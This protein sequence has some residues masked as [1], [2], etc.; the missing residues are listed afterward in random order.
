M[1]SIYASAN[2][3]STVEQLGAEL[4]ADTNDFFTPAFTTLNI[5]TI[6]GGTAKNII[7]G[8]TEMLLEWRPI[9]GQPHDRVPSAI[10]TMLDRLPTK[11]TG[12][13]ADLVVLRQQLGFETAATSRLVTRIEAATQRPATSIAFGSEASAWSQIAEE[14]V[15]FGPGDMRTAHSNRECVPI[16]ELHIAVRTVAQL[17]QSTH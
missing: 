2:F 13:R 8:R 3:I 15:V 4:T 17:M 9:P 5:G 16:E 1:S 12:I 14:I 7:P 11:Y 10:Q 6:H